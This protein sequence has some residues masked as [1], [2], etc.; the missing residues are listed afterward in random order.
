MR[1]VIA[2]SS[3]RKLSEVSR[4]LGHLAY[5]VFRLGSVSEVAKGCDAGVMHYTVAH[6]R[7]GGSP[8]I[9]QA[10]VVRNLRN[11]G[12]PPIILATPPLEAGAGL[13]PNRELET[14]KHA[15]RMINMALAEWVSSPGFLAESSRAVCLIHLEGAGLDFG[16]TE[17]I[18]LGIRGALS[19]YGAVG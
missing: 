8:V 16:S 19:R 15:K 4:L 9:G 14:E 6:S 11:D 7:Y 10:Q 2:S 5:V 17:A 12:A 3:E 13:G 1:F 18:C